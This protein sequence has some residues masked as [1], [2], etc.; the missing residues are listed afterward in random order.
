MENQEERR[1]ITGRIIETLRLTASHYGL[2]LAES[3]HQFGLEKALQA[4]AVA[5]DRFFALLEKRLSKTL[6]VGPEDFF[7]G[8]DTAGLLKLLDAL[9]VSWLAAD[10]VWFQAVEGEGGMDD[11]KRVNDTCW[12][13]FAALE[14]RRILARPDF[15]DV[16]G[17]EAVKKALTLRM[18]ARINDWEIVEETADSFVFRMTRCRVQF[19]RKRQGLAE[20][21]CKSGGMVEYR[22]FA[23]AIDPAVTV[24][25]VACPP[26]EHAEGW[27]CA[28]RFVL[29]D[30]AAR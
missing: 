23:W 19:A 12:S 5:G 26:D 2:W 25:C 15:P 21:P 10:G 3:V 27:H 4:E 13:R 8:L 18:A 17:L 6:G 14:A 28:W 1:L 29:P 24:E 30:E 11:A 20:Y 22:G 7:A 16:A 9:S